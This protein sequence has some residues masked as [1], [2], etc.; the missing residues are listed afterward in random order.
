LN[1]GL[2][3]SF[4]RNSTFGV[5]FGFDRL[6]KH[7]IHSGLP[8]GA[9]GSERCQDV[10]INPKRDGF[11]R[12]KSVLSSNSAKLG[13]SGSCTTAMGD[14]SILPV[15]SSWRH[16]RPSGGKRRSNLVFAKEARSSL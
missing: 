6:S 16:R 3:V 15:N 8:T 13:N 4:G 9:I 2:G 5:C 7:R 12:R 1:E 10:W 14:D 11:F